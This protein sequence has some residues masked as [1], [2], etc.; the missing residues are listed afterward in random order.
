M[1][2]PILNKVFLLGN[3]T[4]EPTLRYVPSGTAVT[5]FE[6]IVSQYE[7]IEKDNPDQKNIFRIIVW[8][9]LARWCH[10]QIRMGAL[11]FVEGHIQVRT[12]P[13]HA[14]QSRTEYEIVAEKVTLLGR[15]KRNNPKSSPADIHSEREENRS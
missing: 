6:L 15:E 10:D 14:G 7:R 4:E 5:T 8:K 13:D 11:V 2:Q 12:Y 1:D 3:V 9:D